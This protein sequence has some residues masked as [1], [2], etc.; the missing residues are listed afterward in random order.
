MNFSQAITLWRK[1]LEAQNESVKE[2][3][4]EKV[5]K[6]IQQVEDFDGEME[7]LTKTELVSL[8][9]DVANRMT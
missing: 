9:S 8:F 5:A 2:Y 6:M 7:H 1:S 4:S 3:A